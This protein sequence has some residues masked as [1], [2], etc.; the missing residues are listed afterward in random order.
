M[1]Q[2]QLRN[3]LIKVPEQTIFI[4]TDTHRHFDLW[5]TPDYS[6]RVD[7]V[8]PVQFQHLIHYQLLQGPAIPS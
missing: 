1:T 2:Q 7:M 3:D 5:A 8:S 4:A 6:G